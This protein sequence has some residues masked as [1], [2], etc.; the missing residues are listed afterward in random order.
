MEM[1]VEWK[2]VPVR[3]RV[4]A[5]RATSKE[6]E[7]QIW[8]QGSY[9][10]NVEYRFSASVSRRD[11]SF[12]FFHHIDAVDGGNRDLFFSAAWPVN[13]HSV[14][15]RCRSETEVQTLVGTRSIASAAEDVPALPRSSFGDKYLGANGIARTLGTSQQL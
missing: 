10:G 5:E 6:T 8:H 9:S 2:R 14:H 15:F 13:L 1:P 12:A 7:L 3:R 11:D 4:S